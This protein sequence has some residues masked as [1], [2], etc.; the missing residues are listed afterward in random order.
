VFVIEW[1]LVDELLDLAQRHVFGHQGLD[2]KLCVKQRH[3]RS[4]LIAGG[5]CYELPVVEGLLLVDGWFR[6]RVSH[7]LSG[8]PDADR[9]MAT[10]APWEGK[11]ALT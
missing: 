1:Q 4:F 9:R 3:V 10:Q 5:P 6:P 8:T 11:I 2:G 7:A